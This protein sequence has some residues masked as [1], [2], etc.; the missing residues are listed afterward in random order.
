M[1]EIYVG[2]KSCNNVLII[3]DYEFMMEGGIFDSILWGSINEFCKFIEYIN[4]RLDFV[5]FRVFWKNYL[6]WGKKLILRFL[7]GLDLYF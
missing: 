5:I 1:N 3:F 4:S 6:I 7:F 2:E